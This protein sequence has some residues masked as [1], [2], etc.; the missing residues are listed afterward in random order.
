MY[1][2][3]LFG[4]PFCQYHRSKRTYCKS[5]IPLFLVHGNLLCDKLTVTGDGFGSV[6]G[7]YFINEEKVS[8]SPYTPVYK[9]EGKDTYIYYSPSN[10]CGWR[11][12]QKEDL[13][14]EN[15]CHDSYISKNFNPFL[16]KCA[17][18]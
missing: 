15:E 3:L 10:G 11:I 16:P 17:N 2:L 7:T 6:T 9:L 13:S 18:T 1:T 8:N 5:N 14:R 12:G 4:L